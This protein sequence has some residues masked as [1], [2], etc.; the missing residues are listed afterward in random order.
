MPIRARLT[1]SRVP[2]ARLTGGSLAHSTGSAVLSKTWANDPA[3]PRSH[4]PWSR[5]PYQDCIVSNALCSPSLLKID[6]A[7]TARHIAG[8][9]REPTH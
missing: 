6:L 5:L 7:S 1:S 4:S 8:P 9:T 2:A 3:L